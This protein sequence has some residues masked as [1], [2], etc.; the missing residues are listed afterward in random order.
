MAIRTFLCVLEVTPRNF[1]DDSM[2]IYNTV[3]L[4]FYTE[5]KIFR[6]KH[7]NI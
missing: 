6:Q 2:M 1:I 3:T 7:I 4:Y 5:G